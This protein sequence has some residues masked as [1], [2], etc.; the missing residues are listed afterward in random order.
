M[1]FNKLTKSFVIAEI[2]VNHEGSKKLAMEM[3][4]LAAEVGVD[5]VKFQTYEVENYISIEQPDRYARAKKFQ[6]SRD[7]FR[8]IADYAR[9]KNI[10]FFSTPLH[11]NDVNF[12]DEIAPIFKI[13]SGDLTHLK[14]ISEVSKRRKPIIIS[15]GMGTYQEIADAIGEVEKNWP[16]VRDDGGLLLMHCV[17]SYPTDKINANLKNISWLIDNFQLPVG[18]SDH[19]IG[20]DACSIA[21]AVGAVAIEKH[22]TYRIEGQVF[23]DHH[24]SADPAQMK[25][26]VDKIKDVE[27]YLG[28]YERRVTEKPEMMQ[29]MRRS[30]GCNV[31]LQ[32]GDKINSEMLTWL[33]PASGIAPSDFQKIVGRTLRRSLKAGSILKSED[34]E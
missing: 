10:I 23:H 25:L 22:F 3:I 4:N 7:S 19:T 27:I 2:G 12:L 9:K 26:L 34:L 17:A 29:H 1:N 14:L 31:D 15:T 30:I 13:S 5:A 11:P 16:S 21:I 33:R 8:E 24:I 20:V 18:Y 6:L 32:R 28:N